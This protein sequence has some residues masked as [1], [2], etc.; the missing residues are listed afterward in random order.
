MNKL[1]YDIYGNI[2]TNDN[3]IEHFSF[4]GSTGPTGPQGIPGPTCPTGLMGPIGPQGIPGPIGPQSLQGP[5]GDIGQGIAVPKVIVVTTDTLASIDSRFAIYPYNI[6]FDIND[7][8]K[9][10]LVSDKNN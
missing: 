6:Y 2:I 10:P 9:S 3:Q 5:K 8:G 7:R 4:F 1:C